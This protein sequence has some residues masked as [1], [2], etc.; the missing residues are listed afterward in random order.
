MGSL[1][2]VYLIK[3]IA[4]DAGGSRPGSP[5]ESPLGL[6]AAE[7]RSAPEPSFSIISSQSMTTAHCA[8]ALPR[9]LPQSSLWTSYIVAEN[10]KNI[11]LGRHPTASTKH[12]QH[13][14]HTMMPP[15]SFARGSSASPTSSQP[16]LGSP[17]EADEFVLPYPSSTAYSGGRARSASL[18]S[19]GTESESDQSNHLA[20]EEPPKVPPFE[21]SR[22]SVAALINEQDSAASRVAGSNHED[23]CTPKHDEFSGIPTRMRD[24]FGSCGRTSK[25]SKAPLG[26]SSRSP[27]LAARN[28][29]TFGRKRRKVKEDDC[30]SDAMASENSRREAFSEQFWQRQLWLMEHRGADGLSHC[31]SDNG[32]VNEEELECNAQEGEGSRD[33]LRVQKPSASSSKGHRQP[34]DRSD[35]HAHASDTVLKTAGAGLPLARV[36]RVMKNADPQIKVSREDK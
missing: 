11:A 14:T 34:S 8:S 23:R 26:K 12:R 22:M 9:R 10:T 4:A 30:E 16:P 29:D 21:T 19:L 2:P 17:D 20:A 7:H 24:V 32:N 28:G 15:P 25:R 35:H 36:K 33:S 27:D 3:K 6:V 31:S 18:S 1:A 13:G 5:H